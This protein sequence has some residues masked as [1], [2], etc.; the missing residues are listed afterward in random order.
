MGLP[1]IIN[2]KEDSYDS[3]FVIINWLIKMIYYKLV[4]VTIDAPGL[5]KVIIDIVVRNHSLLD[6]IVINQGL[7]FISKFRSL[8]CYFLDIKRRLSIVIHSKTNNQIKK[9]NNTMEA[10][11]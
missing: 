5:V 10:Y 3:I 6:L 4:K 7:L 2:K 11:L 1:I 9:Q 8:L